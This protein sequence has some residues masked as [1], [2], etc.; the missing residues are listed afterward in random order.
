MK[1]A[2]T[3]TD[4]ADASHSKS[5]K[6]TATTAHVQ[7]TL[8][9]YIRKA[10]VYNNCRSFTV[11]PIP[12]G[13]AVTLIGFVSIADQNHAPGLSDVRLELQSSTLYTVF[14]SSATCTIFI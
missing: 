8:L 12:R 1:E 13:Y 7:Y 11:V 2:Q 4:F 6:S 3:V 14:L 5:A 9:L 10:T